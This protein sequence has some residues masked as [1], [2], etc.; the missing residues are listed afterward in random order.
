MVELKSVCCPESWM[1]RE[2]DNHLK[3]KLRYFSLTPPEREEWYDSH[4]P[5]YT[6]KKC[7]LRWA[8]ERVD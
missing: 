1:T 4:L 2:G 8:V 3:V 7:G 5:V 6:C